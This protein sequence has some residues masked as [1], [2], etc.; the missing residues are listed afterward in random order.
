MRC[1]H[2]GISLCLL[3]LPI[4]AFGGETQG[5]IGLG[6]GME[7]NDNVRETSGN[8]K[9]DLIT[10]IKPSLLLRHEG[11]RVQGE[12]SYKGDYQFHIK[13]TDYDDYSHY[14]NI[15]AL[16]EMVENLFFLDVEEDLQPV[17][18][19]ARRG[20]VYEGDTTRNQV[21]RNRFTVS[22]YFSL[23]P[24]DRFNIRFG[25]RFM[26]LRY[27]KND[28]GRGRDQFLPRSGSDYDFNTNASQ[29]HMFF[30]NASHQLSDRLT[31]FANADA[32]RNT[33]DS[34]TTGEENNYYRYQGQVGF[35]YA[36]AEDL[37]VKILAGPAYTAYDD[38]GSSL[39]PYASLDLT[40]TVGRSQFSLGVL[41][42]FTDDPET[43]ESLRHSAYT[44]SWKK[45]FDRSSLT[46]GLGYHIYD[47]EQ[48]G[49]PKSNAWR[50]SVTYTY[51]LTDRLRFMA[52]SNLDIAEDSGSGSSWAYANAGFKYELD[53]NAWL[54]L[55]YRYKYADISQSDSDYY[56][57]GE[58]YG[59]YS[60][61]RIILEF[62][63]QF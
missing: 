14:L 16:G 33:G 63:M 3:L 11:G 13:G 9:T 25:Y 48:S 54:S 52:G 51:E 10:H 30:T 6:L 40:Q 35:E 7:Y 61:N 41:M 37:T 28:D 55:T 1:S 17:Y 34:N 26:D 50:P 47:G 27:S 5:E 18:H 57:D 32:L 38:G 20:D 22:P 4:P 43:G 12:I 24:T 23:N 42:D 45:D 49:S 8:R 21:N 60:V 15:S 59:S 53:E 2:F 36:I 44:V 31:L 56:S 19:S 62:Y 58:E 39:V 29:Q 46:L